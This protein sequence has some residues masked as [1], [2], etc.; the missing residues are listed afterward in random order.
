MISLA[1][2][3]MCTYRHF[4]TFIICVFLSFELLQLFIIH[5]HVLQLLI[6]SCPLSYTI[7]LFT[8]PGHCLLVQYLTRTVA[9]HDQAVVMC[10]DCQGLVPRLPFPGPHRPLL[11]T[12]EYQYLSFHNLKNHLLLSETLQ[13]DVKYMGQTWKTPFQFSQD[14]Q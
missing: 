4:C 11:I 13:K 2:E 10:A 12:T 9:V 3:R 5:V 8:S 6:F 14:P 7:L 1:K